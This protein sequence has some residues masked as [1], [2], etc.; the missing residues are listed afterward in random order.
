MENNLSLKKFKV[1]LY[2]L[3]LRTDIFNYNFKLNK[4]INYQ[5][6]F[7]LT[8]LIFDSLFN[9]Q[10]NK[11]ATPSYQCIYLT[12]D[13]E[14]N[15]VYVS[16]ETNYVD[17][18]NFLADF[19]RYSSVIFKNN[20]RLLIKIPSLKE[21]LRF[22]EQLVENNPVLIHMSF[23]QLK[24]NINRTVKKQELKVKNRPAYQIYTVDQ[25]IKE[26]D[27]KLIEWLAHLNILP[28][29][30]K[31]IPSPLITE[32]FLETCWDSMTVLKTSTPIIQKSDMV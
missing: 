22:I 16:E 12:R 1:T 3:Y 29:N 19:K 2:N 4:G 32:E 30:S 24:S 27:K 31:I 15:I 10:H 8:K 21:K 14:D 20:E 7:N 23:R 28:D 6:Y 26:F 25:L 13:P 17:L 9:F 18:R 5:Q 11:Y